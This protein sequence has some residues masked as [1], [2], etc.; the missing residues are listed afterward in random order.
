VQ[1]NAQVATNDWPKPGF[2]QSGTLSSD[3]VID[4][5]KI[6]SGRGRDEKTA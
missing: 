3:A 5:L 6:V 1:N 2:P 4:T